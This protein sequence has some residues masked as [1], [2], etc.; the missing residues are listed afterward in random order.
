M[1]HSSIVSRAIGCGLDGRGV[2]VQG[3]VRSRILTSPCYLDQLGVHPTSSR[4]GTRAVSL[5]LKWQGRKIDQSP[6][7]SAAVKK[8]GSIH[9]LPH[10][11]YGVMLY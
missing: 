5:G 4:M 1:S 7:T 2:G 11:S 10:T 3:L 9:P 8:C 6:P